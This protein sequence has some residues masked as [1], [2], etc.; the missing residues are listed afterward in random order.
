MKETPFSLISLGPVLKGPAG[1]STGKWGEGWF[2]VVERVVLLLLRGRWQCAS[3]CASTLANF[4]RQRAVHNCLQYGQGGR[5][6]P[7]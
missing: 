5:N 7:S 6:D 1:P 3:Q 4:A 2:R